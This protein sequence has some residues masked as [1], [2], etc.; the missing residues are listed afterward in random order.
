MTTHKK[1]S[2][3]SMF[4]PLIAIG[5]I[6]SKIAA[7]R[8]LLLFSLFLLAIIVRV[9]YVAEDKTGPFY[10]VLGTDASVYD[11]RAKGLMNGTWP[12]ESPFQLRPPG[13][14]LFIASV[15]GLT[16]SE[17]VW[18]KYA[19]LLLGA[20]GCL[21]IFKISEYLFGSQ[22][23]AITASLFYLFNGVLIFYESHLLSG[24]LDVFLT[25]LVLFLVI[26]SAQDKRWWVLFLTG[27]CFGLSIMNRGWMLLFL[28]FSLVWLY[29]SDR[30]SEFFEAQKNNILKNKN[31]KSKKT[32]NNIVN[33]K[34]YQ[35]L[36]IVA[37][38]LLPLLPVIWQNAKYDQPQ[39][40]QEYYSAGETAKRLFSGNTHWL[41]A[42]NIN[43]Y[44]GNH[45]D[46]KTFNDSSVDDADHFVDFQNLRDEP[47]RR[48]ITSSHQKNQYFRTQTV[49]TVLEDP[50]TWL[51]L[52]SRKFFQYLNGNEIPRAVTIYPYR[53]Y[54]SV[55]SGLVWKN[56]IAFPSGIIIPLG[57][58]GMVLSLFLFSWKRQFP[59][60]AAIVIHFGFVMLFF[61]TARY[62][63][64]VLPLLSIYAAFAVCHL[65]DCYRNKAFKKLLI[66]SFSAII[67]IVISNINIGAMPDHSSHEYNMLATDFYEKK[68]Y[69]SAIGYYN[70]ALEVDPDSSESHG[71]LG[72][73]Y[74]TVGSN[75]LST[76][77][78]KKAIQYNPDYVDAHHGLGVNY[79]MDGKLLL[80]IEHFNQAVTLAPMKADSHL[81][82]LVAYFRQGKLGLAAEHGLKVVAIDPGD[83]QAHYNL[84]RVF[85]A[86]ERY[87]EALKHMRE[88]YRLDPQNPKAKEWILKLENALGIK[89]SM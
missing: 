49:D 15:Y 88:S 36:I 18:V 70:K 1:N 84:S 3:N 78:Y 28:P 39:Q 61:V 82:L 30:F 16:D 42:G 44:I 34:I 66:T 47:F 48:G 40:T 7:K 58:L 46:W 52:M 74:Q 5:N 67:L 62:R 63:L 6:F 41:A 2:G 17:P 76:R 19:Q 51:S 55:L 69:T 43:L 75:H 10:S 25:L 89:S 85:I 37:A 14:P 27:L 29:Y 21:L 59:L 54:S 13:Y 45:K 4:S 72:L 38:V 32:Q 56:V 53:E 83:Y 64:A 57:V 23:I 73:L 87:P 24:S 12:G 50:G 26:K 22:R 31:K 79:L 33:N 8:S 35:T 80:A 77:H 20:I 9:A 65:Y 86:D 11:M 71:N 68:D 81:N 60:M